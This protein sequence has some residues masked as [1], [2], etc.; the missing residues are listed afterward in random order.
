MFDTGILRLC[1]KE[2]SNQSGSMPVEVLSAYGAA[3]YGERTVSYTRMYEARGANSQV[4]MV[5]RVPFDTFIRPDSYVVLEGNRQF[6]VDAV[7]PVIVRSNTRAQELTLIA[8]DHLLDVE[9]EET[10]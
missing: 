5:V 4:D 8:I 3:Y 2:L 10:P 7:S 6:R 9:E 1:T